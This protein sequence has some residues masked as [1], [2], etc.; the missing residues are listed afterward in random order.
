MQLKHVFDPLLFKGKNPIKVHQML[1][2]TYQIFVSEDILVYI[3]L[4]VCSYCIISPFLPWINVTNLLILSIFVCAYL[5]L[6]Y[7]QS[8]F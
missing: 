5:K 1:S 7:G 2:S 3:L 6:V 4:P 8:V